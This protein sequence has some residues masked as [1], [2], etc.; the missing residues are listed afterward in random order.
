[1]MEFSQ[2]D[3]PVRNSRQAYPSPKRRTEEINSK[4]SGV[5]MPE[6]DIE[7]YHIQM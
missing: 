3:L 6:L 5:K 2:Y 1:M 4:V 7:V